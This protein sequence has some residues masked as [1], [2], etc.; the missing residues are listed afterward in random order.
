[1]NRPLRRSAAALF[2]GLAAC[3]GP[4]RVPHQPVPGVDTRENR[5]DNPHDRTGGKDPEAAAETPAQPPPQQPPP[6]PPPEAAPGTEYLQAFVERIATAQ[7]EHKGIV[8]VFPAL[9]PSPTPG[10]MHVSALGE[11]LAD[12]TARALESTG[13]TGV[14]AADRLVNDLKAADRKP[15]DLRGMDDVWWMAER[16]GAGYVVYG[17]AE[18]MIFDRTKRDEHLMV[19]WQCRRVADRALIARWRNELDSGPLAERM[20]KLYDRNGQWPAAPDGEPSR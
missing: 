2:L 7:R 15:A 18:R 4:E 12:D 17:R 6:P 16:V 20:Q 5:V 9:T 11:A 10:R 1:M 13:V 14:L 19:D 3:S 8:A